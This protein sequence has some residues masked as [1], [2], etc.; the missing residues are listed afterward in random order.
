MLLA[1]QRSR[2]Q[3]EGDHRRNGISG[4]PKPR[5]STESTE[6]EWCSRTHRNPPEVQLGAERPKNV[7]GEIVRANGYAARGDQQI[8]SASA[9]DL[10][11][12]RRR[13]VG[14]D[15]KIDDVGAGGTRRGYDRVAIRRDDAIAATHGVELIYVDDLVARGEHRDARPTIHRNQRATNRRH[16][17]KVRRS[18]DGASRERN[19]S[20]AKILAAR[21]HVATGVARVADGDPFLAAVR[22]L[23]ANDGIGAVGKR[24]AGHD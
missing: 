22:V 14:N 3:L 17:A 11:L 12:V 2:K 13:V 20:R 1:D 5:H 18:D 24:G 7:L 21:T 8:A 6:S 9:G 23:D 15:A 16:H 19:G 4:K 10:R